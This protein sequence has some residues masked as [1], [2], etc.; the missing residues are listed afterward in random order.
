MPL[1]TFLG[2]AQFCLDIAKDHCIALDQQL[3]DSGNF[4]SN[5]SNSNS[6]NSNTITTNYDELLNAIEQYEHEM[7]AVEEGLNNCYQFL[8]G[9]SDM[10][11]YDSKETD[12][13]SI[14]QKLEEQKSELQQQ[15]EQTAEQLRSVEGYFTQK[16]SQFLLSIKVIRK[17]NFGHSL[18][19]SEANALFKEKNIT[20][21]TDIIRAQTI[22]TKDNKNINFGNDA[23]ANSLSSLM[24]I[25]S[26]L[27]QLCTAARKLT[28]NEIKT[29]QT[30]AE[31]LIEHH[32]TH[33]S[34][35][36]ITPKLHN[37]MFHFPLIAKQYKTI[38]LFSEHAIESVHTRFKA[39]DKLYCNIRE[40]IKQLLHAIRLHTLAIDQRIVSK[41]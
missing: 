6:N 9:G 4:P 3:L 19:G 5:N 17:G 1:H 31:E 25:V 13:K 37:L 12:W 23:T 29:I 27:Y 7:A 39:Y 32:K 20:Q 35:Y 28:N 2:V 15:I 21:L 18:V 41:K 24:S 11:D 40:P 8:Y 30:K 36:S 14:E 38:G 34:H 22:R 10:S 33:Y 16:F 26:H